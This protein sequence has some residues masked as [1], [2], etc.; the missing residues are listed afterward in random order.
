MIQSNTYDGA[1]FENS[2]E[3]KLELFFA[4]SSF[5]YVWQR[6]KYTEYVIFRTVLIQSAI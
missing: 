1:F 2:F 4:K 3:K 5:I 6:P